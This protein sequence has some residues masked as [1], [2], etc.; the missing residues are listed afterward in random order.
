[1]QVFD[2]P[3][4]YYRPCGYIDIL[5]REGKLTQ[6]KLEGSTFYIR[7]TKEDDAKI[8]KWH[9]MKYDRKNKYWYGDVSLA[10]LEKVQE[11]GGLIPPAKKALKDLKNIQAAVN[12][13]KVKDN[14]V[15]YIE[16]P[17]K[18]RLYEHQK[19]AFNMALMAFGII[20][21]KK[22]QRNV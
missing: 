20:P 15:C 16:P 13:E 1:M 14:V 9:L 21:A 6:Q 22:E 18:A 7:G 12:S 10:L 8:K 5:S 3:R 17:V 19:R 2:Y 11:N 4:A